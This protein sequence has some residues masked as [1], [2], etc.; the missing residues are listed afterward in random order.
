MSETMVDLVIGLS[1]IGAILL[2]VFSVV[3]SIVVALR[4]VGRVTSTSSTH[5]ENFVG[6]G[7]A[8]SEGLL[9]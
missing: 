3:V 4:A 5:Q 1:L 7:D 2:M 9:P 6:N 8:G